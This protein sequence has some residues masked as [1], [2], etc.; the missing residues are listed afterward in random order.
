MEMVLAVAVLGVLTLAIAPS[1]GALRTAQRQAYVS[2]QADLNQRI[3]R[4]ML[5]HA[6]DAVLPPGTL[7][8]PCNNNTN[9]VF[10]SIYNTTYCS[11]TTS[12]LRDYLIQEQV[13]LDQVAHDGTAAKNLRVYQRVGGLSQPTY[14]YAQGGPLAYL[15]YEVGVV[16]TTNC[17]ITA[18]CNRTAASS[19]APPKSQPV[20]ENET[21]ATAAALRL[22]E[23]NMN[24]WVPGTQDVGVAYLSTLPLQK[25]LMKQTVDHLERV[26][27]AFLRYYD[28]KRLESPTSTANH[29]PRPSD[30]V[31]QQPEDP[32]PESN[33]GCREGWY[34]LDSAVSDLLAQVGL[35][36]NPEFGRTAWGGSIEYCRDY[37]PSLTSPY[38]TAPHYGALRISAYISVGGAPEDTRSGGDPFNNIVISF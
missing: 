22:Q 23:S 13:P 9:K 29:F 11:G 33:Q 10:A 7:T 30:A 20:Y 32:Y 37:D 28:A 6:E 8:P 1:L 5:S 12:S 14:L 3:V 21:A 4:A 31:V 27:A 24:T 2:E 18:P 35:G 17:S 25:K 38:N 15:D 36:V 26:R 34:L 16:Y 19:A